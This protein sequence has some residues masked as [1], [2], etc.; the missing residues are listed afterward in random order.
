M[1]ERE[2]VALAVAS[3]D[4]SLSFRRVASVLHEQELRSA[5]RRNGLRLNYLVGLNASQ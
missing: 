1:R 4:G 5:F 3:I 2:P